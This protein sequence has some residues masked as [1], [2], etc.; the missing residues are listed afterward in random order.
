MADE[1]VYDV[2]GYDEVTKALLALINN[3]PALGANE[4][5][6]FATLGEKSGKAMF[7]IS[8]AIVQTETEDITGH[9]TQD[10][11]YP[12]Y[13]IYQKSGLSEKTKVTAKEWLD[14]LGR[15]LE[16]Q[17]VQ[18][19]GQPYQ[20]LNYPELNGDRKIIEVE[21]QSPSYLDSVD[22]NKAEKWAIYISA[23]Y[24]NDFEKI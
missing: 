13:V 7:P 24:R 20:L 6:E 15:W 9:V 2:D 22:D 19:N 23:R 14:N 1:I 5:I 8:G 12:F 4:R 21:R 10:C 18:I 3:Y 16:R 17:P 11:L